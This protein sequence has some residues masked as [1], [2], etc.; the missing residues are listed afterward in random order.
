MLRIAAIRHADPSRTIT[1]V[2]HM[3]RSPPAP[4]VI[5]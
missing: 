4:P 5:S 3:R 1:K 2:D